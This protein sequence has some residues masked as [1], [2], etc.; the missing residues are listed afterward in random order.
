MNVYKRA[1]AFTGFGLKKAF[2]WSPQESSLHFSISGENRWNR[3][4]TYSSPAFS[5][6]FVHSASAFV[7]SHQVQV[8]QS[9]HLLSCISPMWKCWKSLT[10]SR[11]NMS[12]KPNCRCIE[13]EHCGVSCC[14]LSHLW[15][16]SQFEKVWVSKWRFTHVKDLASLCSFCPAA[17]R[18]QR[19]IILKATLSLYVQL[20]T[21]AF[22]FFF[23][24]FWF[25]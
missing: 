25:L 5:S 23:L 15:P 13:S 12:S 7:S 2:Q 19:F 8:A 22:G 9:H 1:C 4:T 14:P 6:P 16:Y 21:V 10:S 18:Q 17:M 11:S 24:H 3:Q 20:G